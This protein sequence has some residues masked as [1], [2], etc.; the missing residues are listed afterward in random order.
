MHS[1]KVTHQGREYLFEYEL[2]A[3]AF[4][5]CK[6]LEMGDGKLYGLEHPTAI[7][8]DFRPMIGVW[9]DGVINLS[10]GLDIVR[11]RMIYLLGSN[12]KAGDFY[13][14]AISSLACNHPEKATAQALCSIAASLIGMNKNDN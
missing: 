4:M 1:Y 7:Y 14:N 5:Y 9:S 2:E 3:F 12:T 6:F 8:Y 13:N 10:D 11:E